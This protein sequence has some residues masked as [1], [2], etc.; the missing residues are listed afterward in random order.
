MKRLK[1]FSLVLACS[2]VL[3]FFN[4]VV[5]AEESS[6]DTSEITTIKPEITSGNLVVARSVDTGQILLDTSGN[7]TVP[8]TV[9]AKLVSAM[10]IFDMVTSLTKP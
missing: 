10:V 8:P 4:S 1:I 7:A 3:S 6:S 9:T 5:F 2:I